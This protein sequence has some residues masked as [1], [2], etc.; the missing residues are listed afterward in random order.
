MDTLSILIVVLAT[1]VAYTTLAAL[2]VPVIRR[3]EKKID[4][5]LATIDGM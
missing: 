2:I 3:I 1:F 5:F 4:S